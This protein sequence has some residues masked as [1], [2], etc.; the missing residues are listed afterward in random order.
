MASSRTAFTTSGVTSGTG[1]DNAKII[2]FDARATK[3]TQAMQIAAVHAIRALAKEVVPEEV[4]KAYQ[5]D[6]LTFGKEYILPKLIDQRLKLKVSQA[7]KE[8][9]ITSEVAR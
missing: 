5:L 1:L 8:A 9:A 7:V 3:M 6:Q 4:L 2:G